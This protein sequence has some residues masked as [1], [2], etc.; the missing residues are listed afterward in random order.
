MT[1]LLL[2]VFV[3]LVLV[4]G[5]LILFFYSVRQ[6]DF[7]HFDRMALFPLEE[8]NLKKDRESLPADSALPSNS[9]EK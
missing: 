8:D 1:I 3:S 2:Q 7:E 4:A 5:G 9:E 6:K